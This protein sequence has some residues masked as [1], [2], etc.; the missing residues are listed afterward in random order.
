[1]VFRDLFLII[2]VDFLAIMG[3]VLNWKKESSRKCRCIFLFPLLS[4][5]VHFLI[6]NFNVF[7]CLVYFSAILEIVLIFLH[8]KKV[9]TCI[10]SLVSILL[11]VTP[12][13][14]TIIT[15]SNC[16]ASLGYVDAF[17]AFHEDIKKNY[18]LQEWKEIDFD[19]KYQEYIGQFKQAEE[20]HDT[21]AYI[22]AML[23]YLASYQD[24]H[25]QMWDMYEVFGIGSTRNIQ[26]T[27]REIYNNYYGMTLIKIDSGEYV[28]A[29]V[30]NGSSADLAGIQNGTII[31]KWDGLSIDEQL[32]KL[33][34]IIP[35]NCSMFA[36]KENI[37]RF[38]PFFLACMGDEKN[39]VEFID[40]KGNVKK[41]T[42]NT[43][44]NG[45]EYLYHTIGM[46]LQKDK[47]E[48]LS[49]ATLDENV[50]YLVIK[51]M[52]GDF[53]QI[54]ADIE[55]YIVQMKK[56]HITTLIV[57]VRNNVG[58]EDYAGKIIAEHFSKENLF[59]LKETIYDKETKEYQ[60]IK[61]L[62]M[63][64]KSS[65][66]VPIYL[67]VNSDCISAGEGFAYNMAKLPQVTV[68]GMT[69]TNGSFGTIDGVD[70]MPEGMMGVFPSI[71]CL[72]ED[73]KI[74]IDSKYGGIG[75]IKPEVLIPIDK[76]AI[77]VIFKEGY[78][79]EMSF[80]IQNMLNE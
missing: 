44:G 49:Y 61:T 52:G 32:D 20:N 14:L 17:T 73:G 33:K 64:A 15:S 21:S 5:A 43:S 62:Q 36:D 50:G 53:N 38:K 68:V 79:Y 4:S 66:D 42:L 39:E 27:Y 34:Y 25:V 74:M 6:S 35:V 23:S 45:Y 56:D 70:I 12:I 75:G 1:M 59:Y 26:N 24:G 18:A 10:I 71:A 69:G 2:L 72:D 7:M 13:V 77:G 11:S 22:N 78:D 8:R 16:Y 40:E 48:D 65:I 19:A 54:Q 30:E 58:G 76:D 67:L 3:I 55:R 51:G 29:N 63:D 47:V 28:A 60:E 37:E 80:I 9:L 46:F 57:D 41:E 31:T